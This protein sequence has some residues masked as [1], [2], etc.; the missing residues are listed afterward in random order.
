MIEVA[1]VAVESVFDWREWQ[2]ERGIDA[3]H[4]PLD[5]HS[6]V[7][8]DTSEGMKASEQ[9]ERAKK[10][11]NREEKRMTRKEKRESK[12]N[13][14]KEKEARERDDRIMNQI[15]EDEKKTR[16]TLFDINLGA[17]SK[18]ENTDSVLNDDYSKDSTYKP[19]NT[20]YNPSSNRDYSINNDDDQSSGGSGYNWN[21]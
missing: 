5:I 10:R 4:A 7:I 11:A 15:E 8:E 17:E 2:E 16:G 14:K 13:T 20:A 12:L 19:N 3:L 9:K 1:I 21:F 6:D 18:V